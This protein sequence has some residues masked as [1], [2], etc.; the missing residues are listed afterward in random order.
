MKNIHLTVL[1]VLLIAPLSAVD[2]ELDVYSDIYW[3]I[4]P[5]EEIEVL[6]NQYFIQPAFSGYHDD[7]GLE[8]HLRTNFY[9]QLYDEPQVIAWQDI[10]DEAYLFLPIGPFD[11]SLGQKYHFLGFSDVY[12][13][14]NSINGNRRKQFSMTQSYLNRQSDL[15]L[16]IQYY[17]T[18]ED[19]IEFIYIP[20]SRPDTERQ[21]RVSLQSENINAQVNLEHQP[22]LTDQL[23]NFYVVY[24]RYSFAFDIQFLYAWYIDHTPDFNLTDLQLNGSVWEGEIENQYN[25]KQTLGLAVSTSVSKW[26]FSQEVALNITDNWD[27][28]NEGHQFSDISANSQIQT[29]LPGN[30]LSQFM[31]IYQHLIHFEQADY[32][33]THLAEEI[34]TFHQQPVQN[35]LFLVGHFER[36]FLRDKL[37]TELNVAYFFSPEILFAPELAYFFNDYLSL[38]TGADIT[39]GSPTAMDL[40]RNNI[41]DNLYLRLKYLY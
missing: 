35:I 19:S 2:I 36:N 26:A 27:G 3:N 32:V 16:H 21:D 41:D 37:K 8:W 13:S 18:F 7:S 33:E 28:K 1:L 14:L 15:M 39:M 34:Q 29:N 23:H 5:S 22:Y 24:N 10:I 9:Y 17:P 40:R 30:I 38:E 11:I 31:L 6:R 20:F 4:E 25:R 12:S